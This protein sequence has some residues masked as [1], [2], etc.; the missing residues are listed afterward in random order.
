MPHQE[1]VI[2]GQRIPS[3]TE[4][5]DVLDKKW[6]RGWYA[7]EELLRCIEELSAPRPDNDAE[8]FEKKLLALW[9]KRAKARKDETDWAADGKSK[10][11]ASIG[12]EFHTWVEHFLKGG[13]YVP[14]P[15]ELITRVMPLTA[16]FQRFHA[17]WK[18]Q[19]VSQ[20]LHVVSKQYVY[21]G[22]FDFLGRNKYIEGLGIWDWKTSN[23]IDDTY[24]LQIALY[25]YAYGEQQGW[26]PEQTWG[27]ITHGGTV[28]LD[29]RT[30]QLEHKIYKDLPYLFRVAVALREPWDYRNKVGAWEETNDS[31]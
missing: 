30:N 7:K 19:L 21:Q 9:R 3:V 5:L 1:L 18:L 20:E 13:G 26:T 6:L 2:A 25:A 17:E 11:A 4:W 12:T 28:R 23:K 29:K 14:Q 24:G 22:T 16:E 15:P 27:L 31:E 8:R 10:Q